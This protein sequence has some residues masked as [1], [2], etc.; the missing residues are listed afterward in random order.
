MTE[1]ADHPAKTAPSRTLTWMS[2]G[3]MVMNAAGLLVIGPVIGVMNHFLRQT[4]NDYAVELPWLTLLFINTPWWVWCLV[5]LPLAIGL[6]VL[7]FRLANKTATITVN[8][9]VGGVLLVFLV[10]YV[11][12]MMLPM[13]SLMAGRV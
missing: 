8:V 7:E 3:V 5:F 6:F 4:F 10:T 11:L 9:I 1:A 2:L 12:A 13:V